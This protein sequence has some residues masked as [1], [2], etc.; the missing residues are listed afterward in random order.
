LKEF[1]E[2]F[3]RLARIYWLL[4]NIDASIQREWTLS[5]GRRT[6]IQRM[7][8]LFCEL[9]VRLS[10]AG[11]A[12]NDSYDLPL[13]QAELA[14]CLGL[15]S[16]HVNRTLQAMRRDRLIDLE[17]RRLTIHDLDALKRVAEFNGRYLYV[18]KRPR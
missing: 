17:G 1:T 11:L 10:I 13:T 9:N 7:A 18:E 16:V 5:L 12:R 6:A 14:E 2:R 4:T 8:Q 15:T 3:P